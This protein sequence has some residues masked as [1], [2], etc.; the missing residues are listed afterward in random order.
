M[1]TVITQG[2]ILTR[3]DYGEADRIVTYITP[4][5]GKLHL[6]AKGARKIKSRLAGGIELFSLS[7]ISF[8]PGRKE[9]GTLVSARLREH[10]PSITHDI[11][12]VQQGYALLKLLNRLT[13]DDTEEQYF[14]LIR[15]TLQSLDVPDIPLLLTDLWFRARMLTF[16][17][18]QPNL[19]SDAEGVRLDA[20]SSYDFDIEHMSFRRRPD[21]SDNLSAGQIKAMRLLF[22]RN[23]PSQLHR[24]TGL[25]GQLA[26]LEPPVRLMSAHYLS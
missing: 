11:E 15:T 26:D 8:A 14:E 10:Y 5:N 20:G 23:S 22:S 19:I 17:G 4:D 7:D 16:L 2:I 21:G 1:R 25:E 9:L 12:R 3:V 18:H 6:M 13:E 24:V